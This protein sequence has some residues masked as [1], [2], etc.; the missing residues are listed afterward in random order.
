LKWGQFA[1]AIGNPFGLDYTFTMGIISALGREIQ[2]ENGSI[3]SGVIQTDAAI[4]PGNSGGPLLD[5]AGRLIGVNTA[6][7]S[8]SK[9]S[10]GIGFAIPVDEVNRVVPQLI[11]HKRI[12]RPFLG[13]EP[14]PDRLVRKWRVD[15]VLILGVIPD[16]PAARA[17][18]RPVSR[19]EDGN[20][21]PGDAIVA[22]DGQPIRS[23]RDLF[24][25]LGRKQ[26]GDTVRVTIVRD[27]ERQEKQVTL[28]GNPG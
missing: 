3:I 2:A 20:I 25:V 14:V 13:I 27:G 12:V 26:A 18:L 4:N 15:G 1:Y 22:I 6:I 9:A 28:A 5:S 11:A 7:V 10:V 19:D 23:T 24:A 16:S 17:G 8:P 21:R